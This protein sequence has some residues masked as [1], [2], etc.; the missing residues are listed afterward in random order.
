[1]PPTL[2]IDPR[3]LPQGWT[4]PLYVDFYDCYI[5]Y[6]RQFDEYGQGAAIE[7]ALSDYFDNLKI[8]YEIMS[9]QPVNEPTQQIADALKPHIEKLK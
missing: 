8:Y 2:N 5:V 9:E 4:L 1:M 3:L 6:D 7:E